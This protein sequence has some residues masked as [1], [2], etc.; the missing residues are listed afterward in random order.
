MP[1]WSLRPSLVTGH[2]KP[3]D[4]DPRNGEREMAVPVET[5][6][7]AAEKVRPRARRPA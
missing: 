7:A 2:K 1:Q 3:E 5:A 6:S 4:T